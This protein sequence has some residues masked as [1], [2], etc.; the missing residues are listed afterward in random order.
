MTSG[1][2]LVAEAVDQAVDHIPANGTI[3]TVPGWDS[4]GHVRIIMSLESRLG[5]P[6][7][8]DEIVDL[9]SVEAIDR[10]LEAG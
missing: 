4:L 3:E 5:R 10:L 6:L 7:S 2:Q 1:C 8:A 9:I